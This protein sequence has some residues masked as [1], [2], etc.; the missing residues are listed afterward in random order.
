M[1][2]SLS[3]ALRILILVTRKLQRLLLEWDKLLGEGF[4]L[5]RHQARVKRSARVHDMMTVPDEEY[6]AEQYWTVIRENL[7]RLDCERGGEYLDLGCGQGRLS[8]P[9][10]QW[11]GGAGGKVIGVDLS[12]VAIG[13]AKAYASEA[14]VENVAFT[15]ADIGD[16]IGAV[17]DESFHGIVITEVLYF[18]PEQE[19]VLR[20]VKRALKANGVL[21]LSVRSQL[22]YALATVQEGTF[23]ATETLIDGRSGRLFGDDVW[24]NWNTSAEVRVFLTEELDLE[25]IDVFGIGCCSGI[26]GDP[27]ARVARPSRLGTQDRAALMALELA[28]GRAVPDSGRYMLAVGRQR[29]RTGDSKSPIAPSTAAGQVGP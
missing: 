6:Y 2:R 11:C 15:V 19:R 21:I 25:V 10:A 5:R 28:L 18:L 14:G 27:H 23:E 24:F 8:L 20:E 3:H 16:Y 29:G 4:D 13:R 26:A 7:E 22:F 17:A 1:A 12:D 9:L